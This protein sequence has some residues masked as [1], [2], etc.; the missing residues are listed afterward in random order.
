MKRLIGLFCT[1]VL[2]I[3]STIHAHDQAPKRIGLLIVATGKY[4][5]FVPPLIDSARK[6]FCPD[7]HVTYFVFTDGQLPPAD[8]TVVLE[9]QKMGW[10]YDTMMRCFAYDYYA[11]Y[12]ADM[13]YLFACDADMLFVDYMRDEI[14]GDRVGTIHPGFFGKHGTYET[15]PEC[16]AYVA[17]G[18]GSYYFAG[19]FHGGTREEFL[20]LARTMKQNIE[21]DAQ[22]NI[23]A[24]WHDESHLN[25]YFIDNV[26]TI[27]LTPA[28]CYPGHLGKARAWG[29]AFLT[30]KLLALEKDHAAFRQ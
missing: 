23:I 8:D 30:P 27:V 25:R 15:R 2:M 7:H 22:C 20:K 14:L 4:I 19:G 1:L 10:P 21:Q 17:P 3:A 16:T 18:E 28:Y 26:P 6:Y 12:F 29:I 11:D 24:V 5:S 9:H 13:D